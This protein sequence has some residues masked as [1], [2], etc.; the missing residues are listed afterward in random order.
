MAR[1]TD[2]YDA[3]RFK[4]RIQGKEVGSFSDVTGLTFEADVETFREG[5]FNGDQRYLPGPAKSSGRIV[6]KRG[7]GKTTE[8]WDWFANVA[9][10]RISRHDMTISLTSG[11]DGA[12]PLRSWDFIDACPV[13]WSG[14]ELHAKTADIAFES[15][16]FVHRGQ[17]RLTGS[18]S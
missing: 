10:G 15:I 12:T 17:A 8:L 13:K 9:A 16:E 5:G 6:L 18:R 4:V 7:L 3:F 2:P 14:P 11:E 1:R